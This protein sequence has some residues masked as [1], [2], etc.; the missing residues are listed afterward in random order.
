MADATRDRLFFHLTLIA[1][2]FI[3]CGTMTL[4]TMVGYEVPGF[5]SSQQVGSLFFR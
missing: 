2:F 5:G 4:G 3:Q 1:N